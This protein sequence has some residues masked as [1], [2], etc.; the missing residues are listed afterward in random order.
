MY[1]NWFVWTRHRMPWK[2]GFT[3][4]PIVSLKQ[5]LIVKQAH[6]TG[7]KSLRI[8][9]VSSYFNHR[10]P[11]RFFELTY[12]NLADSTIQ[13]CDYPA[14]NSH[15]GN[16][17]KMFKHIRASEIQNKFAKIRA[18]VSFRIFPL[19]NIFR[20]YRNGALLENGSKQI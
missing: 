5:Y 17:W 6:H 12:F 3:S 10:N 20:G 2:R 7:R 8:R 16:V 1:I 13:L 15:Q 18:M 14:H 4:N 11:W 9:K 19:I